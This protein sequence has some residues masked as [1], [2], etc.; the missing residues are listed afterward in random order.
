MSNN[1]LAAPAV[2]AINHLL[3]QEA[4][5]RD[6]LAQHAGKVACIDAGSIEARMRVTPDGMLAAAGL[7][8]IAN[9]TIRIKL[10]DLPLILQ[11]RER[12]FSYVSIDGD[13]EF[14]NTM[15]QLSK[16]L[17]WE[18]EHDLEKLAGPIAAR[19]IV[20]GARG[21]VAQA[22]SSSRKLGENVAEYFLDEQ[23]ML[24][25]PAML[26]ELT[27]DINRVR[28]DVERAAKRLARLEQTLVARGA[29]VEA[30][31]AQAGSPPGNPMDL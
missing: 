9:V 15:S 8:Q 31:P 25:R 12:A 28:D 20:G 24:V 19:R 18:A 3:A 7:D 21:I 27:S 4:W 5:A 11:H 16:G 30:A 13:A 22:R 14:A 17:R 10:S 1:R 6:A 2:A 26:D 23:P 29:G